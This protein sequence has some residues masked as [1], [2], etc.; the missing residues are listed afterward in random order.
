[1]SPEIAL[2]DVAG[3]LAGT[4]TRQLLS[5]KECTACNSK[6]HDMSARH[7]ALLHRYLTDGV[8][9]CF[10]IDI[11]F[12]MKLKHNAVTIIGTQFELQHQFDKL[13]TNYI[14]L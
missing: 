11:G 13:S 1:M 12:G 6:Q 8:E 10:G 5:V 4:R 9:F 2:V 14:L 3:L 7:L